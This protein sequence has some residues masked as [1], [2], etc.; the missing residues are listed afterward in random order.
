MTMVT[1]NRRDPSFSDDEV[2]FWNLVAQTNDG[3]W[4][5][6]GERGT[7]YL[8]VFYITE[9]TDQGPR[10]R[11]HNARRLAW[12]L[13]RGVLTKKQDVQRCAR[14]RICVNPYRHL[15][16]E[17]GRQETPSMAHDREAAK[18]LLKARTQS[19]KHKGAEWRE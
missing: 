4:L 19:P 9:D 16:L 17:G 13:C 8:P 11:R 6:G 3:C 15:K 7:N 1:L 18:R 10:R 12:M 2:R 5:W 14:T